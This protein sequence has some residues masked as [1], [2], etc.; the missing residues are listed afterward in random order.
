VSALALR[1]AQHDVSWLT[2]APLWGALLAADELTPDDLDRMRRPTLLRLTSDDFMADLAAL[3]SQDAARLKD[4]EAKPKSFRAPPPGAGEDYEPPIDHVK[5]YQAAHGHF[6][7]VAATLVCRTAGMPDKAVDVPSREEVGFVLRRLAGGGELAWTGTTWVVAP[8][9]AALAAGEQ[10]VPLFPMPY[11]AGD[12]RRRLFVGLVPTSSIETY[13]NGGGALS[14]SP[15]PGDRSGD[16]PDRRLEE[17]EAKVV[18]PLEG[19]RSPAIIEGLPAA[20]QSAFLGAEAAMRL[21]ASRFLL[22]DLGDFLLRNVP[23]LWSAVQARRRPAAGGPAAAYDLLTST[24]ADTVAG[25]SWIDALNGVWAERERIWGDAQPAPS[26]EVH[27]ERSTMDPGTLRARLVLALPPRTREQLQ[28]PV[29]PFRAPKLDPRSSARYVLR[30]VY[31][32]P[33]CGPLHPDLVSDPSQPFAIASFFDLDAPARPIH[34]SLPIDTS[35]A[36]LRKAPK[37]VSFLISRELR[38]QMQR[39]GDAKKAL[40]GELSSADSFDLGMLC[41]FSI[42]IITIC[43]LIVL[44]IFIVLLNILFWWL[45]FFRI[46][47][48][49][50]LKAK[51]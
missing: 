18:T 6:N 45:P 8:P 5:L 32:R 4:L 36:G 50:P 27:L 20:D 11:T 17:L 49:I 16:P 47:F 42:P 51:G 21:E 28:E 30:C 41:S 29:P 1:H 2:A 44:M 12:R 24:W 37:N 35:I 34:I 40:K 14:L 7:L 31:R 3:L 15:Q 25:S 19:L 33:C 43:A 39:V 26:Y 38:A 13:K 46:C 48:P 22:L 10:L 9:P 23:Q